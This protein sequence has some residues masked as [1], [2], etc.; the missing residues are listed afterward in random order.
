MFVPRPFRSFAFITFEDPDVAAS[1][2]GQDIVINGKSLTVGSAV[3]KMP[4][5]S[6]GH[7]GPGG[8]GFGGGP[9]GIG[10]HH[11]GGHHQ[12]GGAHP[13]HGGHNP[14]GGPPVQNMY[15][16]PHQGIPWS[17][18]WITYLPQWAMLDPSLTFQGLG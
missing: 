17:G 6:F 5:S 9:G 13:H 12:H 14:H 2:L 15:G 3:P 16:G 7:H 8:P 18:E 10:G 1:L 11:G 4:A